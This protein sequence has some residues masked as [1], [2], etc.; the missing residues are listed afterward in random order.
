MSLANTAAEIQPSPEI[1]VGQTESSIA[2]RGLHLQQ[3]WIE[4]WKLQL[5]MLTKLA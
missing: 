1:E 2:T 5:G 3:Q 4:L